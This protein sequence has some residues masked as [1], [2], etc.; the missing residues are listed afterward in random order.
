MGAR[1]RKSSPASAGAN[2]N[3]GRRLAV[4]LDPESNRQIR[5]AARATGVPESQI[6][7]AAIRRGLPPEIAR[8]SRTRLAGQQVSGGAPRQPRTR[9][10]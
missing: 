9:K 4:A 10:P 3:P 1:H 6:A 2:R 5:D 7:A 8:I